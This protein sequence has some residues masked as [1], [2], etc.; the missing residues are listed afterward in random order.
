MTHLTGDAR[1]RAAEATEAAHTADHGRAG[2]SE[3]ERE[4]LLFADMSDG[5]IG[6][7]PKL[8]AAVEDILQKR[9]AVLR[10][11]IAEHQ[12]SALLE[13]ADECLNKP[14]GALGGVTVYAR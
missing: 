14:E 3:E 1:K 7:G 2:L 4:A 10:Q 12:A 8:V 5:G 11:Y 6:A 13:A 9:M